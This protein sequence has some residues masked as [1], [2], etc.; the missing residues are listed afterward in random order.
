[1][2]FSVVFDVHLRG[3]LLFKKKTNTSMQGI[4]PV[5][6]GIAKTCG[7]L[8]QTQGLFWKYKY[9]YT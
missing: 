2:A 3:H 4:K 8:R 6:N 1:M 7:F 9:L 5:G